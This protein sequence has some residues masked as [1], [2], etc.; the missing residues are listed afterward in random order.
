MIGIRANISNFM[1][2]DMTSWTMQLILNGENLAYFKDTHT[3]TFIIALIQLSKKKA[4]SPPLQGSFK[5][6]LK[7]T[8]W[9]QIVKYTLELQCRYIHGIQLANLWIFKNKRRQMCIWMD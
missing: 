9:N 3:I 2:Y 5:A 8:D 1:K 4:K 6:V 7:V